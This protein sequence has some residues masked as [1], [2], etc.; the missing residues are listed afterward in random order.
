MQKQT[1]SD[2]ETVTSAYEF[3]AS[4][5]RSAQTALGNYSAE[6]WAFLDAKEALENHV[7]FTGVLPKTY[8]S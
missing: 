2:Y 5:L 4:D 7:D 3:A 6:M 1:V 8:F